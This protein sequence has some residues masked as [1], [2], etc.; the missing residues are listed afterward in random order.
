MRK[1]ITNLFRRIFIYMSDYRDILVTACQIDI[2][3]GRVDE[4]FEKISTIITNHTISVN[5]KDASLP[6]PPQL[7]IFPECALTGYGFESIEK[8]RIAAVHTGDYLKNLLALCVEKGVYAI[9]GYVEYI[10]D[11]LM[12]NSAAL[13][14]PDD[15]GK[16]YNYRKMHLPKMGVDQFSEVQAS[17]EG[18]KVFELPFANIGIIICYDHG[19]PESSR[20]LALNGAELI[21][22]IVNWGEGLT[23]PDV[24]QARAIDN[25]VAYMALNRVGIEGKDIYI[26]QSSLV[27]CN[28][29]IMLRLGGQEQIVSTIVP[30]GKG[31]GLE[32]RRHPMNHRRP[33]YYTDLVK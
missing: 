28:G 14:C 9:V 33:K 18:F 23:G 17:D 1:G 8:V 16:T 19:F 5:P 6:V 10:R 24:V 13:I 32:D 31:G 12:Y 25:G 3:L 27:D 21:V 26:G 30:L 29:S 4:N 22:A 15:G 11:D 20:I 2:I 7:I